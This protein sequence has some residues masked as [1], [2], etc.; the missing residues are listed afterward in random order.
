MFFWDAWVR[1]FLPGRFWWNFFFDVLISQ[2]SGV[3]PE[4][5]NGW[6]CQL[7]RKLRVKQAGQ[8]WTNISR[9]PYDW[10]HADG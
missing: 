1:M 10:I 3:A 5:G 8:K 2:P 6:R 9:G 7:A 4:R